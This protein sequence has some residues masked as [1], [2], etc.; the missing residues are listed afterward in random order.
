MVDLHLAAAHIFL[1]CGHTDRRKS[2]DGLSVLVTQ[3]FRMDPYQSALFLFC[4]RRRDRIKALLWQEDGLVLLYKRLENGR[5]Q[6]PNTP[7]DVREITPQQ[8][9]WL[10]EG[11]ALEQPHAVHKIMANDKSNSGNNGGTVMQP[12]VVKQIMDINEFSEMYKKGQQY[13]YIK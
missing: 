12:V 4:G 8:Y 13:G 1:A 3:Q 9:R 5:F 6:W 2:I 11:L 10:M 7:A